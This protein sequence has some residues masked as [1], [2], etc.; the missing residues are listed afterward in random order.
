[1][2]S[3]HKRSCCRAKMT[4]PTATRRSRRI[5]LI[6]IELLAEDGKLQMTL[7]MVC[8]DGTLKHRRPRPP[9]AQ[10]TFHQHPRQI[11]PMALST[12]ASSRSIAG[13][14]PSSGPFIGP[15]PAPDDESAVPSELVP[16]EA[17]LL[18]KAPPVTDICPMPPPRA[19]AAVP[20]RPTQRVTQRM[21][22]FFMPKL[23]LFA[24]ANNEVG[25]VLFFRSNKSLCEES[26]HA[27]V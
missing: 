18:P 8:R 5:S 17:A 2:S 13:L 27:S 6:S 10:R 26:Q 3:P 14:V 1:M 11:D 4:S 25:V 9:D 23:L 7:H 12:A 24:V 21:E 16:G 15:V 20:E 19:N 22:S